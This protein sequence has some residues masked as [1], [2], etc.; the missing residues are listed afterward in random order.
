MKTVQD[1]PETATRGVKIWRQG[2]VV[3]PVV[4]S[5]SDHTTVAA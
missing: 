5:Q 4:E 1:S 3:V 2:V